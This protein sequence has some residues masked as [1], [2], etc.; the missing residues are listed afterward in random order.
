MLQVQDL[1]FSYRDKPI[2]SQISFQLSK[3]DFTCLLGNNGSGK[4]TILKCLNGLLKPNKGE[5]AIHQLNLKSLNQKAIALLIAFVPQEHMATFSFKV[6]DVVLMGIT[7][8]L[9]FGRMPREE[10]Y[11]RAKEVM[12]LIGILHLSSRSYN[13]LSGGEK[14]LVLIGRALMQRTDYLLLDEPTSHLDFK[15]QHL[16]MEEIKRMTREG[17]GV[18]IALHDPNLALKYCDQAI[19][20]KDGRIIAKGEAKTVITAKNL[21]ET[22]QIEVLIDRCK[23]GIVAFPRVLHE[24]RPSW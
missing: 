6:I 5:I 18:L 20:I 24:K 17:K 14:Q 9:P 10:D 16:F 22:Y 1:S 8:H 4:T 21:T 7:P 11:Q 23:K 19:L 3:G 13:Q 12:Q 15:N 2:L